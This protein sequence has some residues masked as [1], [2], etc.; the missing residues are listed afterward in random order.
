MDLG[1]PAQ[2]EFRSSERRWVIWFCIRSI[3]MSPLRGEA[4]RGEVLQR[5]LETGHEVAYEQ[6]PA[7]PGAPAPITDLRNV[8]TVLDDVL[9]VVN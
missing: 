7:L 5:T 4:L 1:V 3:N 6:V 2:L 8:V 9:L